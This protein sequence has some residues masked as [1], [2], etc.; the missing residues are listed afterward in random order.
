MLSNS[1]PPPPHHGIQV[2]VANVYTACDGGC[3]V[4]LPKGDMVVFDS[5]PHLHVMRERIG[6]VDFDEMILKRML[7]DVGIVYMP[8][9]VMRVEV[10]ASLKRLQ[11][12]H[13]APPRSR[14]AA[15]GVD[16]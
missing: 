9:G 15:T 13:T 4:H 10:L 5:Y 7:Q 14:R 11:T 1:P 3:F 2:Y 8:A 16:M 6:T 12:I